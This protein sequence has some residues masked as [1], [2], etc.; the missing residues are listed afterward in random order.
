MS[1]GVDGFVV[2]HDFF[3]FSAWTQQIHLLHHKSKS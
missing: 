2:S 1:G 3:F